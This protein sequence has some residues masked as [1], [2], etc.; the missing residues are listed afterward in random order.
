M[1]EQAIVELNIPTGVPLL[2]DLDANL[3]PRSNRY[4]GDAEAIKAAA[5]AVRRQTEKR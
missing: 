2:Y 1:S 4:L 5:E 3:G